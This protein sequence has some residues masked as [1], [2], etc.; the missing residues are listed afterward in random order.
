M[1]KISGVTITPVAFRDPPLLNSNGVHEPF[2]LRAIVEC[3][4]DDGLVGLGETYGE[5]VHLDRLRAVA[6]TIEGLDPFALNELHHK[7]AEA[8]GEVR[9]GVPPALGYWSRSAEETFGAFEVA[10]F[11]IQGRATGRSVAELLGGAVRTEVPYSAYLFYRWA[12][13]PADP[14]YEPDDWGAALDPTGIVAQAS[15]MVERYGFTSLKLKGGVFPP[16]EEV[17]AIRALHKAF[18]DHLLR[19]DPNAAWSVETSIAV[20]H[21]LEGELEYLEDPTDGIDAMAAVAARSSMP[22]ATNMCVVELSHVPPAIE[23]KAVG[24]VLADHHYWGGLSGSRR[25]AGICETFGV[26]LSMHSNSHLGI[27]LAAMTHLAAATSNLGY[28]CDTHRLWQAGED[29]V[30]PGVLELREG[31]IAVPRGPGLGVELDREALR[32]LAEQYERCGVRKRDDTGYM[33]RFDPSYARLRP[34]W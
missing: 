33:Q 16:A 31:S 26:G 17:E 1:T 14:G 15:R 21:A 27:S 3:R 6:P 11:D 4:T 25:L 7:V 30:A 13:H 20:A 22:L 10:F 9:V 5:L 28:A 23:K 2:A 19:I 18:P 12:E 29:V 24:I 8:L 32:E 34:R